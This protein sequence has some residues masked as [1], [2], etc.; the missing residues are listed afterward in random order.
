MKGRKENFLRGATQLISSD[1]LITFRNNGSV[2]LPFGRCS[3][4]PSYGLF[5]QL[6]PDLPLFF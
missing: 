6:P 3:Q 5:R 1:E 2:P 4:V